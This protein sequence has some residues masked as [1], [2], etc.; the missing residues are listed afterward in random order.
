M[1]EQI[2]EASLIA[3]RRQRNTS[4]EKAQIKTGHKAREIWKEKP[5]KA[6]HQCASDSEDGAATRSSGTTIDAGLAIAVFGYKTH[7]AID[8]VFSFIGSWT[9]TRAARH[10]G[11]VLREI[12]TTDN[13]SDSVWA[14]QSTVRPTRSG[15]A[16]ADWSTGSTARSRH[17]D[18]FPSY[19]ARPCHEIKDALG[20]RACVRRR[21]G[22]VCSSVPSVSSA[23]GPRSA[24]PNIALT[25]WGV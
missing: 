4:A 25:I 17:A 2:V 14:V 22:W 19:A 6:V 3:A 8:Q 16:R 12:A 13:T 7:V 23:P 21:I 10:D 5:N 18:R 11:A 15:S 1:G 20:G 24:S 9:V